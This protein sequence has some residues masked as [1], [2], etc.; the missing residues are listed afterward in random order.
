M[1]LRRLTPRVEGSPAG[2]VRTS[3]PEDI[4]DLS[5][6]EVDVKRCFPHR[7]PPDDEASP[8]ACEIP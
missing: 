1:N 2:V 7:R 3:V 5:L 8:P 4:V 6:G